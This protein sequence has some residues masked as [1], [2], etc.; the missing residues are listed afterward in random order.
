VIRSDVGEAHRLSLSARVLSTA[1][2]Q[3]KAKPPWQK[4]FWHFVEPALYIISGAPEIARQMAAPI[5]GCPSK[6]CIFWDA[7]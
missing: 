7:A 1:S 2:R 5:A 4:H 3:V 6:Q